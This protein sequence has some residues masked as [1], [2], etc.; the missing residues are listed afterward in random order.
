MATRATARAA[1]ALALL[2]LIGTAGAA[3]VAP[4]PGEPLAFLGVPAGA[5]VD[6]VAAIVREAGGTLRCAV[7]HADARVS[8]CRANVLA[9]GTPVDVW[10][11]AIEGTVAVITFSSPLDSDRLAAW[12]SDVQGRYGL[13]S[14][15][16]QGPQWMLQWVRH[17]QML[18]LTWRI[19]GAE[20]RI[21]VSLIDGRSLDGWTAPRQSTRR[22]PAV[23]DSTARPSR[24]TGGDASR[25]P[26]T[27]P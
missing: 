1:T 6:T 15:R 21:S 9:D 2:S 20:K 14:A 4:G 12:R 11:S 17:N 26:T 5:N 25:R 7:S 23:R 10:L 16:A 22:S 18:R 24:R 8:D 13:V 3:Q 27:P 19:D